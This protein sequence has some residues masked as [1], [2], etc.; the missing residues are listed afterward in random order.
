[1]DTKTLRFLDI[2]QL[3]KVNDRTKQFGKSRFIDNVAPSIGTT[4]PSNLS[5]TTASSDHNRTI[6]VSVSDSGTINANTLTVAKTSGNGQVSNA[7]YNSNSNTISFNVETRPSDYT[8]DNGFNLENSL[9][10]L[11][12]IITGLNSNCTVLCSVEDKTA[13]ILTVLESQSLTSQK[14]G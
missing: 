8:A 2:K 4:T 1:M 10:V 13:P 14:V 11:Q 5:L 9:S 12:T 6:V 7:T 3:I